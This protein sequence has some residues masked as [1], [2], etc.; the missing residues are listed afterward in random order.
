[1]V[2]MMVMMMMVIIIKMVMMIVDD[3]DDVY[4]LSA[5]KFNLGANRYKRFSQLIVA[6]TVQ[7]YDGIDQQPLSLSLVR[8]RHRCS[9][10]DLK[11]IA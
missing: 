1:M 8:G 4:S 9:R 10:S 2:V 3:T 7:Q 5:F 6:L 11:T